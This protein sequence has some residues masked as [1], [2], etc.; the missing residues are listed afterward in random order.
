MRYIPGIKDEE[1]IR[2]K[3]PM[4]KREIRLYLMAQANFSAT[5]TVLD[6]GAGTG[7]ISIEA[8]LAAPLGKVY[9]VEKEIEGIELIKTNAAKFGVTNLTPVLGMAPEAL[10][11]LP[12]ADV[13]FV[14]GSGGKLNDILSAAYDLLNPQGKIICTAVTVETLQ[15]ALVWSDTMPVEVDA[16]NLQVTRLKK[17]GRYHMF[18]ALNPISIISFI[19]K[20]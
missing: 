16:C 13:I 6:I 2:G 14:G 8:A 12:S 18:E 20:R 17:A 15:Q 4:T 11:G 1:F 10:C 19:Q 9:A 3:V 7:S 5:A